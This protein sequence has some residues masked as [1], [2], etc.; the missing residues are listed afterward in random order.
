MPGETCHPS[1]T[2][3]QRI[4]QSILLAG[5]LTFIASQLV[6]ETGWNETTW[7]YRDSMI[8]WAFEPYFEIVG[9]LPRLDIETLKETMVLTPTLVVLI[10]APW[11]VRYLSQLRPFSLMMGGVMLGIVGWRAYQVTQSIARANF[12]GVHWMEVLSLLYSWGFWLMMFATLISGI[13]L[14]LVPK[15]TFIG[16][17]Q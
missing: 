12:L 7:I 3:R 15:A 5:T 10:A 1:L 8:G 2:K 17:K 14:L 6:P 9:S 13:G 16:E 4:A 11:F